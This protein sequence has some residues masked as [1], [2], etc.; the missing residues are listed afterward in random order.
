[1]VLAIQ[2]RVSLTSEALAVRSERSARALIGD[3]PNKTERSITAAVRW[4]F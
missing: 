4:Q 2:S 1:M 3:V